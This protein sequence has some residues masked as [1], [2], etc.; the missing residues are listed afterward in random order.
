M[1]AA[2]ITHYYKCQNY[3]GCLQAYALCRV[4]NSLSCDAEQLC[5]DRSSDRP[6]RN[7]LPRRLYRR[8]RKGRRA[9]ADL[10]IR[11]TLQAREQRMAAFRRDRIP[12]SGE[13]YNADSITA[14]VDGYDCF[15]TGSDQVWNPA[16]FCPAYGLDFVPS[17]KR[18]LSYAASIA[19]DS[20]TETQ[21]ARLSESLRD[22]AAVS[23]REERAKA[24]LQPHVA[25]PIEVTADPVLLLSAAQWDEICSPRLLEDAYLF[26]FFLGDSL[27]QRELARQYAEARKLRLVTV[28]YLTGHFRSCDRQ[29]GDC[30]ID[31]PSPEQ[32]LSLIKH[33]DAVFTDSFHA[34]AFSVIYRKQF[35]AFDRSIGTS[36]GSRLRSL[37][38]LIG[39]EDRFCDTVEKQN[40]AWLE[41]L[42]PLDYSAAEPRLAGLIQASAA[43]LSKNIAIGKDQNEN[44]SG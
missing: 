26:C 23:V 14:C 16:S 37:L 41:A 39:A 35:F 25:L 22:Y 44:E 40:A 4:L 33:A 29:F 17:G 38:A 27:R 30:V 36:M 5:Y 32:F 31:S 18:K 9:L 13:V 11:K 28:P 7:S 42:P 24:I 1:R 10:R 3:G 12:H 6:A 21:T 15:I 43:F 34:A 8:L 2:I 20:L 19:R